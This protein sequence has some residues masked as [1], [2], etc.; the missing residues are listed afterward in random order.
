LKYGYKNIT[1]NYL[2]YLTT[3]LKSQSRTSQ[4]LKKDLER[5]ADSVYTSVMRN[6][7][8]MDSIAINDVKQSLRLVLDSTSSEYVRNKYTA[9]EKSL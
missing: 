6:K 1:M 3:E 4:F 7:E 2:S 8:W 5:M 9:L